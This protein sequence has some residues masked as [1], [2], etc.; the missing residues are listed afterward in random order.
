MEKKETSEA[1]HGK[2]TKE[3]P[4]SKAKQIQEQ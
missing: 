3:N 2:D 1:I 4:K